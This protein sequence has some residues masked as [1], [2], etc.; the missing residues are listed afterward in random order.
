MTIFARSIRFRRRATWANAR[1]FGTNSSGKRFPIR[2]PTH[3]CPS[4]RPV[5][6]TGWIAPASWSSSGRSTPGFRRRCRTS[7]AQPL[8]SSPWIS[9]ASGG[10]IPPT[11]APAAPAFPGGCA[12]GAR[13]HRQNVRVGS[14]HT[15]LRRRVP[16]VSFPH[17]PSRVSCNPPSVVFR[18][19]SVQTANGVP[20]HRQAKK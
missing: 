2:W 6:S 1:L 16:F 7:A 19:G 9:D 18:D 11:V 13:V 20:S 15:I 10:S 12:A 14:F 5:C 17:I 8:G 3:G 4:P